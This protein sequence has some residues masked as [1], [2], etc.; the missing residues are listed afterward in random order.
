[1]ACQRCKSER[2][3]SINAKCSDLCFA[4]I[5]EHEQSD[6]PPEDVGIGGGDYVEFSYCL[7][8]GQIQGD[9]PVDTCALERKEW[10]EDD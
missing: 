7:N 6:Y 1:M 5:G 8:C 3:M 10:E 9:F 2:I 4:S